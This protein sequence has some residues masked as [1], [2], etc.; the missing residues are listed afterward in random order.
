MAEIR[1][2][3][4]VLD[5]NE[6]SYFDADEA[7]GPANMKTYN[8]NVSANVKSINTNLI[9]NVKSLDTNV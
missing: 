3:N 7:S 5:D 1:I 2:T 9:A 8:T 6:R 4:P